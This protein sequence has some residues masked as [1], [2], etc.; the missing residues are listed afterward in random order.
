MNME[1]LQELHP[2]V[3]CVLVISMSALIGLFIW[4]F[5]KTLREL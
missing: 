4:Q 2:A 5:F 1:N 3:A